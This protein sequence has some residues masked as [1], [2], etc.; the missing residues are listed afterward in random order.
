MVDLLFYLGGPHIKSPEN[1]RK[2]INRGRV[3]NFWGVHCLARRALHDSSVGSK[4][5]S[6]KEVYAALPPLDSRT[7]ADLAHV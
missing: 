7:V 5:Q 3:A 4:P 2:R 6:G 1:K